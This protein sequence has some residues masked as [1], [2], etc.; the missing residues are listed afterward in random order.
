[1]IPALLAALLLSQVTPTPSPQTRFVCK[2]SG[3]TSTANMTCTPSLPPGT[4]LSHYVTTVLL[5][6][7]PVAQTL[8]VLSSTTTAC[9]GSPADV[10]STVYL[11][12]N[13]GAVINFTTPIKTA[14]PNSYLCCQSSG[15]N[16]ASCTVS[17][18]L[19]P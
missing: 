12:I 14:S 1:M 7:G 8:K 16:A 19:A 17:G 11:G 2:V 5:S 6:N 15:G 13:G 4:N 10:T 9:G 3:F 18:Y